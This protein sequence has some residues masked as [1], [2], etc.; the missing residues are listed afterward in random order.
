MI[1]QTIQIGSSGDIVKTLQTAL[2]SKGFNPGPID[3]IFGPITEAAVKSFQTSVN[4][5]SDGI[6]DNLTWVALGFPE[7]T[8]IISCIELKYG[9]T[10]IEVVILQ[11][12]LISKGFNP[13]PVDGYFGGQTHDTVKL[14][15]ESVSLTIDGIVDNLTWVALGFPECTI[16]CIPSEC[17][18]TITQ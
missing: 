14:F 10:G 11:T 9:A 6:V 3:G 15:K 13:G 8:P 1:C 2:I 4:I 17:D 18:F 16:Q 12:A 7:C 5:L